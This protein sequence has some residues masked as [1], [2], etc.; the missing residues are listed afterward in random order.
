MD[1]A[2]V[3][4][5]AGFLSKVSYHLGAGYYLKYDLVNFAKNIT[6]KENIVF[7]GL[8]FYNAPPYQSQSPSKD[9]KKRKEKYDEFVDKLSRQKL[10]RIRQGR[11]RRLKENGK[12]VYSQKGVD[13]LLTMDL[14]ELLMNDEKINT[15]ILIASN[16]DFVPVIKHLIKG[17]VKVILYTF[18]E[19][20]RKSKFSTSNHLLQSVSYYKI[21][22]K[23]LFDECQLSS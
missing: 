15:V 16:T 19:R 1:K 20:N 7:K 12:T 23:S 21:L 11:C 6:G 18:F 4:I 8:N 14:M 10:V 22:E 13:T 3:F 5:D 9:E 17:G 2:K